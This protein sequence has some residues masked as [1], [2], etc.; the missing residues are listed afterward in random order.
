MR[1]TKL[2]CYFYEEKLTECVQGDFKL[3]DFIGSNFYQACK[4]VIGFCHGGV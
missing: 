2:L 4:N 3:G 1:N